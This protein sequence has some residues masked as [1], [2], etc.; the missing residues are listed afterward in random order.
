MATLKATKIGHHYNR[1]YIFKNLESEFEQGKFYALLGPNGTGK[2][3]LMR[4]LMGLEDPREGAV[5]IDGDDIVSTKVLSK[6][7]L[8]YISESIDYKVN[9]TLAKFAK[10]YSALFDTWDQTYFEELSEHVS[11]SFKDRFDNLSRGQK[12]Q[13]ALVLG[14]AS[15]PDFLFIDEITSVLDLKARDYF[16]S[17]VHKQSRRG[18]CVLFATNIVTE[19]QS[20]ADEIVILSQQNIVLKKPFKVIADSFHLL[21]VPRD[22]SEIVPLGD[23]CRLIGESIDGKK[24]YVLTDDCLKAN[25]Q[26]CSPFLRDI[27]IDLSHVFKF[28]YESEQREVN[29]AA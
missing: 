25:S 7:K 13:F 24:Q 16:I 18:T 17:E 8:C 2:S 29:E 12:M 15:R 19:V 20:V 26:F 23:S 14:L 5:T 1:D 27:A 22:K 21:E 3:T 28:Y 6:F 9:L 4:L 10:H 11:F